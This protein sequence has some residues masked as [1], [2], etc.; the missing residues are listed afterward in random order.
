M[1]WKI[2]NHEKGWKNEKSWFGSHQVQCI[3]LI[4][5]VPKPTVG[6]HAA[7]Y[8]MDSGCKV[9]GA[10]GVH[11]PLSGNE[12]KNNW[13]YIS[14]ISYTFVACTGTT[15][16]LYFTN[17]KH[18]M[19]FRGA[20]C[21]RKFYVLGYVALFSWNVWLIPVLTLSRLAVSALNRLS[22]LRRIGKWRFLDVSAII[23]TA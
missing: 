23:T 14:A 18:N 13:I 10:W 20:H 19:M 15:L 16:P 11:S 9:D 22:G 6:A 5:E 4:I 8:S 12:V 7:F 1:L 3:I 21:H 2:P 17:H